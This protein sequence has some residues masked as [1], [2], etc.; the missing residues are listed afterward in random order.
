[1]PLHSGDKLGSYEILGPLGAGGMGV[2]WKA[3]DR[4]LGRCVAIK[5]MKEEA[6]DL[7]RLMQEARAA[8]QLNHPN[9]LTIHE[10]GEQDGRVFVVTE[11]IE[12]RVLSECL[13]KTGSPIKKALKFA[14]PV[15]RALE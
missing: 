12:G 14:I 9:I 5:V 10:I 13:S 3:L 7:T 4:K 8:A 11:F 1:M 15:A 6:G 2:V